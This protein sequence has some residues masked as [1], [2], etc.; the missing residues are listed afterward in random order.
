MNND[1][2]QKITAEVITKLATTIAENLYTKIKNYFKD[3]NAKEKID[4]KTAYEEYLYLTKNCYEKIKTLLCRHEPKD[5]YSFYE[6][7]G[8]KFEEKIVDTNCV[9]NIMNIGHKIIITGTG[10]IG[11]T[12]M[13]KHFF[14]N[15]INQG[16]YIPILIELRKLNDKEIKDIILS[17][18]I[19]EVLKSFNFDL[20]NKY[21]KYSLETGCYLILFDGYDEVKKEIS[22]KVTKEISDLSNK[23]PDNYYILTS[24]PLDEF[25]G[26]C[27]FTELKTMP[28]TKTQALSLINKL[29]YE[30][31]VKDKFYIELEETLFEKYESFASN[32]LLLTIMLITFENRGT[33]PNKLN[34]FYEQAFSALFNA[35]DA[36]KGT[37]KREIQCKLGYE[38]FKRI[39]SYFC[40]KSFFKSQYEFTHS[41]IIAYLEESKIKLNIKFNSEYYLN[42]LDNSV[43]MLIHEGL[44]YKFAHRSFQEYFAAIHTVQ[45]D[46]TMQTQLITSWLKNDGFQQSSSNYSYMLYDLQK[47]RFIKNI[48]LIGLKDLKKKFNKNNNSIDWIINTFCSNIYLHNTNDQNKC[49]CIFFGDNYYSQIVLLTSNLNNKHFNKIPISSTTELA[50]LIIKKLGNETNIFSIYEIRNVGLYDHILKYAQDK[51]DRFNYAMDFLNEYKDNTISSKSKFESMIDSL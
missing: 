29:D 14:L 49:V 13:M 47:E 30:K 51:I 28:L 42:D 50:E 12:I 26:W 35:H 18:Y 37:Y 3:E 43:C 10:G 1:L 45:L 36:T 20:E 5:L 2:N 25:I 8:I 7:V 33:I 21:F 17:D 6:C 48:L 31:E 11:K 15:C 19:Y 44:N 9:N 40:F 4:F 32:P 41:Q 34:D 24:R 38:D 22:E 46:D 27:D 23:Y 16:E 39:F